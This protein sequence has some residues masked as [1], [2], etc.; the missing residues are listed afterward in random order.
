MSDER[1]FDPE[2]FRAYEFDGWERLGG[3]YRK[4]WADMT[5]QA[6]APLLDGTNV[7]SGSN[8]LDVATGPGN[9][10]RAAAGRG[11]AVTGI[12]FSESVL[13]LA[14]NDCPDVTFEQADAEALPFADESFDAVVM[15]F[16]ILHFPHPEKALSEAR[17]V[18][19]PG[20]R[21]GFTN[22]AAPGATGIG[23]AM[24]AVNEH[25]TM[26]V[27]LPVGTDMFRFADAD[28]C[29]RVLSDVGFDDIVSREIPLTWRFDSPDDF[30]T[31]F[32][33]AAP[34]SGGLLSAQSP[35]AMRD[36]R[37]ALRRAALDHERNG[38]IEI[39]MPAMLTTATRE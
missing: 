26:D 27:D 39:P 10:A 21:I 3:G 37:A 13:A 38:V 34:R 31:G 4:Y 25:G 12:D 35:D 14:R 15:N 16:G 9:I 17:R 32:V 33:E 29:R 36:I 7:T 5:S 8:V 6:A 23:I 2:A 20:C 28:E 11:A 19:R 1:K 18:L 30:I 24:R 22:W